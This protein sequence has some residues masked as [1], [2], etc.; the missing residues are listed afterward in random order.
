[1][2]E[3]KSRKMKE[4]LDTKKITAKMKKEGSRKAEKAEFSNYMN[5]IA[6]ITLR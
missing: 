6:S 3:A 1:M 2:F 4:E 5:Y